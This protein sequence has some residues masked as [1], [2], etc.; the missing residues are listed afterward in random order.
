MPCSRQAILSSSR[1]R[2]PSRSRNV[3]WPEVASRSACRSFD[4]SGGTSTAKLRASSRRR[5]RGRDSRTVRVDGVM[6]RVPSQGRPMMPQSRSRRNSDVVADADVGRLDQRSGSALR[7]GDLPGSS[8]TLSPRDERTSTLRVAR[9]EA[10][11]CTPREFGRRRM[12]GSGPPEKTKLAAALAEEEARLRRLEIERAEAKARADALRAQL[13]AV[14]DAPT[15]R[16]Q[17]AAASPVGPRSPIEKVKLFRRLFR[18]RDDLY[19]TR[20]VSKK[21]GKPGYAPACAN[22]FV[23]GLCGLPKVKCGDCTNQA[24]RP[25]DDGMSSPICAAST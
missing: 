23:D 17:P 8:I 20:F 24:F 9:E 25:V 18:G 4:E 2:T 7:H 16:A 12:S 13:A 10:F 19:P 21:T 22:K 3:S 6:R 14:D 15:V 11:S 1:A 5:E